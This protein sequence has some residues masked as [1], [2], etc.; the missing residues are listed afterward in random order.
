ME[1]LMTYTGGAIII[2]VA[3]LIVSTLAL[4]ISLISLTI[5]II[6]NKTINKSYKINCIIHLIVIVILSLFISGTVG[7]YLGVSAFLS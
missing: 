3:I 7:Y 2:T 4:I 1:Q 6:K 5:N